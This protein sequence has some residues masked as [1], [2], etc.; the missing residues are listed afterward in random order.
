MHFDVSFKDIKVTFG[1]FEVDVLFEYTICLMF[2]LDVLGAKELLYDELNMQTS[3]N[4]IAESEILHIDIKEHKLILDKTLGNRVM[5]KRNSIDLTQN[6]YREFLE[7]ISFTTSE[8][9]K[10][11]NDVVLRG[12]R[13]KF[14]YNFEEFQTTLNFQN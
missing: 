8:I 7:D 11:F 9:K 4:I 6:E 3:A 13:I 12:D 5:P 1:Q 14:P 10:W 2:R